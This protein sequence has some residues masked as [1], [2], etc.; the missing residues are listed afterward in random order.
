LKA[1]IQYL[2][3][4]SSITRGQQNYK[5]PGSITRSHDSTV[6]GI[7]FSHAVLKAAR[8]YYKQSG[9]ITSSHAV[10]QAA[11]MSDKQPGS[12]TSSQQYNKHLGNYTDDITRSQ[13]V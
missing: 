13:A 3:T 2:K 12:I 7:T 6:P 4:A 1:A 5:Q 8:Y 10:L 9:N 11:R